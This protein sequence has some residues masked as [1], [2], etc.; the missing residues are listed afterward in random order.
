MNLAGAA[1]AALVISFLGGC[2]TM[3]R[4]ESETE[5]LLQRNREWS[6]A[7]AEGRDLEKIVA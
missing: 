2:A 3:A 6:S 7:A 1:T 4:A 5:A